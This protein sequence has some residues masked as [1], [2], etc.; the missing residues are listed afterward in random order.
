MGQSIVLRRVH[1]VDG[2]TRR[3]MTGRISPSS[4]KDEQ[5]RANGLSVQRYPRKGGWKATH[6]RVGQ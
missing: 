1:A 6:S 5:T 3:A 2:Q 4:A